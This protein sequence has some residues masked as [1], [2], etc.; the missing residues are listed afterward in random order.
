M[1]QIPGRESL[2]NLAPPSTRYS[3]VN[4]PRTGLAELGEVIHNEGA[5]R[6]HEERVLADRAAREA[7]AARKAADQAAAL[8]ELQFASDELAALHRD[9]TDGV[10]S[11]EVDKTKAEQEW[12]EKGRERIGTALQQAPTEHRGA[13]QRDLEHRLRMGGLT[14]RKAVTQRD[15]KDV[16]TGIDQTIEY[17]SRLYATDP[18]KA[19]QLVTGTLEGL[20]PHSGLGQDVIAKTGQLYKERSRL[21][22]A[23]TLV[24][25]AQHDNATL[26]KVSAALGSDE[27]AVLD[28]QQRA[29]LEG[30]IEIF[31]DRN[32]QRVK[33][34]RE[35]LEREAERRLKVGEA[36]WN[37]GAKL[38]DA[39]VLNP[40]FAKELLG[41]M[42]G[43]PYAKGFKQLMEVQRETGP[44]ARQ[45]LGQ[46]NQQLE[47]LNVQV[48]NSATPENVARRDR[49]Q[50]IAN[51]MASDYAK[52]PLGAAVARGRVPA[53]AAEPID[54]TNL[55]ALTQGLAK[56]APH[57]PAVDEA[58]G[59]PASLLRPVEAEKLSHA[60]TVLPASERAALLKG[61]AEGAGPGRLVALAEQ[62]KDK[63]LSVAVG[64]MLASR[65]TPAGKNAAEIYFKGVDAVKNDVVKFKTGEY[66]NTRGEI[67]KAL[68]GVYRTEGATRAAAEAA[69][70]IWAGVK[71][72]NGRSDIAGA[73]NMATG[74]VMKHNGQKIAL[75][76]N[77]KPRDFVD[78][79]K[80][81]PA[82]VIAK[83]AGGPDV[84]VQVQGGFMKVP[85]AEF[86]ARLPQAKL[87]TWGDG[88]YTVSVGGGMV[89]TSDGSKELVIQIGAW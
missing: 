89:L 39:G 35:R 75:P 83:R 80:A 26:A 62:I 82:D 3:E 54:V 51:A 23:T 42:A 66:D 53:E 86:A 32:D 19:D 67:F 64:A 25:A 16:R 11:G 60:L 17:A 31:R 10:Q 21:A 70:G 59:R 69:A 56:R 30:R 63:N 22:K 46:V 78:A 20:G 4:M 61:Y 87:H 85:A 84:L 33:S 12:T 8:G 7:E 34:E 5:R 68:E 77:M 45:S 73:V 14:V 24:T 50:S 88:T 41:Q 65:T 57:M 81:V 71:A 2:G 13:M 49:V 40:D 47:A 74:G 72:E 58:I 1:A 6:V 76:W 18:G 52:D 44:L 28:P 15:Q 9:I 48:A 79:L 55:P 37:T 43:T 36:A 27:Y 29:Q 38:A